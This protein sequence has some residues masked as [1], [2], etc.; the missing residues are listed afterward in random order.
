MR[1]NSLES[2]Q[3]KTRYYVNYVS[4]L[5]KGIKFPLIEFLVRTEFS[6]LTGIYIIFQFIGLFKSHFG[7]CIAMNLSVQL[8]E[9]NG[10]K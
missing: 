2:R 10:F 7:I 4:L 8:S 3:K 5:T 9:Q 1:E 6:C